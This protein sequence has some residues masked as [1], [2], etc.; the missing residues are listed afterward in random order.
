MANN[1]QAL[2]IP[3]SGMTCAAC[4]RKI[5]SSLSQIE[6]I[7]EVSVNLI[8]EKASIKTYNLSPY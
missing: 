2:V 1:D 7:D 3:I 6:G 8:T 4:V 5:E